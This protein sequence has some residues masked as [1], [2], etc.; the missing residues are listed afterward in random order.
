M[1]GMIGGDPLP[2]RLA[3]RPRLAPTRSISHKLSCET[4]TAQLSSLPDS[5]EAPAY[6]E[7]SPRQQMPFHNPHT[8]RKGT[9]ILHDPNGLLRLRNKLILS[10]LYGS[11]SFFTESFVIGV[12]AAA[13]SSGLCLCRIQH[14]PSLLDIPPR[15]C[16]KH[17]IGVQRRR[18]SRQEAVLNLG[19]L[20]QSGFPDLLLGQSVFLER[21]CKWIFAGTRVVLG[22]DL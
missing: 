22:E 2:V 21:S 20:R 18:P 7:P 9:Y 14:E 4:P 16:R 3:N 5:A 12:H 19:I 17:E 8:L 6:P 13:S 15:P 10:S 1:G 11:P